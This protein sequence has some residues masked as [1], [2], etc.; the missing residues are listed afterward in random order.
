MIPASERAK[1]VHTLNR[2]ATVTGLSKMY[3]LEIYSE[4]RKSKYLPNAFPIQRK[5]KQGHL[6]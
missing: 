3:S 2:E 6:L 1:T 4:V 5:L